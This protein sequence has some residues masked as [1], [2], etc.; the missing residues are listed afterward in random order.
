MIQLAEFQYPPKTVY[1]RNF[2][3]MTQEELDYYDTLAW[4]DM[5]DYSHYFLLTFR[6]HLTAG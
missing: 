1:L 2:T 6:S 4:L 3:V 5:R